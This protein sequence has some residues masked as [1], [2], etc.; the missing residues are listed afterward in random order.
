MGQLEERGE[1]SFVSSEAKT[2]S[3][4]LESFH[5]NILMLGFMSFCKASL[6]LFYSAAFRL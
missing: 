2:E 1:D 3:A 5:I 4:L 6:N